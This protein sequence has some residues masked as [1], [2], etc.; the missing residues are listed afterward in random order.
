MYHPFLIGERIY[1]RAIE[2]DDFEKIIGW[3]SDQE[4]TKYMQ[5][6]IYP[7]TMAE[8]E[9]YLKTMQKPNL[10]LA[11]CLKKNPEKHIGNMTLYNNSQNKYYSEISIIIGDKEARGKGY[12]VEAIKLLIDHCFKK[13][14]IHCLQAGAAETNT[15]CICAFIKAGYKLEGK[16]RER[17]YSEG[18]WRDIAIMSILKNEWE[19]NK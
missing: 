11:I 14:D 18:N 15:A 17:V 3:L 6:G 19:A 16:W 7:A 13:M 10:Y 8:M 1:L 5:H 12:A 4:N 2:P 9:A